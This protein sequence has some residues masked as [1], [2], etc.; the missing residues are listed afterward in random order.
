MKENLFVKKYA[1]AFVART[2][3]GQA[4]GL[5]LVSEL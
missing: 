3:S 2:P 4:V 5:A 1:E